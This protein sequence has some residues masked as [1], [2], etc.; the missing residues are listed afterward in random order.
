M[1][2]KQDKMGKLQMASAEQLQPFGDTW[3]AKEGAREAGPGL[4]PGCLEGNEMVILKK[5][6]NKL[7]IGL[8]IFCLFVL[9]INNIYLF[10]MVREAEKSKI[11]TLSV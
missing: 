2:P 5:A 3:I 11:K 10:F 7:R 8:L 6:N 4:G 9:L 1:V